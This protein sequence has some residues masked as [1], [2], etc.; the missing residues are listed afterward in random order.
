MVKMLHKA[1]ADINA[2]DAGEATPLH[3]LVF[4]GET[5]VKVFIDLFF[6]FRIIS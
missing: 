2:K 5:T 3:V 1:G 6:S 4:S